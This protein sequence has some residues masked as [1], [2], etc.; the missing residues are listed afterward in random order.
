MRFPEQPERRLID[1]IDFKRQHIIKLIKFDQSVLK[2][3][4]V[5]FTL[6]VNYIQLGNIYGI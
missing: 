5:T 3:Y 4:A 6:H 1:A 2:N